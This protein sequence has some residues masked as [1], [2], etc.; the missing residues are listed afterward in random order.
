LEEGAFGRSGQSLVLL[1]DPVPR[2][3][4][5]A[6]PNRRYAGTARKVPDLPLA[7]SHARVLRTATLACLWAAAAAG[8]TVPAEPQAG[9]APALP[10]ARP[11]EIAVQLD[12]TGALAARL[13][14]QAPADDAHLCATLTLPGGR[15]DY[16]L[17]FGADPGESVLDPARPG[18]VLTVAGLDA[19]APE[20]VAPRNGSLQVAIGGQTFFGSTQPGAPFRLELSLLPGQDG[21]RFVARHLVDRSGQQV[22]DLAGAWRCAALPAAVATARP[23]PD[24]GPVRALASPVPN[25]TTTVA[26]APEPPAQAAASAAPDMAIAATPALPAGTAFRHLLTDLDH[27]SPSGAANRPP[28]QPDRPDVAALPNPSSAFA[29]QTSPGIVPPLP[30]VAIAS[31]EFSSRRVFIHYRRG[32]QRGAAVADDLARTL[33]PQFARTEIRTVDAGPGAPEIRYFFADDAAAAHALARKLGGAR[34]PWHVRSFTTFV[35]SPLPGTLELW[36]PER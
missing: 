21:G 19:A 15:Q 8:Q 12:A 30:Q 23:D 9:A 25:A 22:I 24:P 2:P 4:G 27:A 20:Q 36:V 31:P 26:P 28:Q 5:R 10:D 1:A 3:A 7:P 18:L 13:G 16:L 29:R 6:H 17:R 33:D 34:S 14:Q 32:S 35:P 11:G